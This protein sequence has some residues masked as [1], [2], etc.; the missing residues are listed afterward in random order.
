MVVKANLLF[1]AAKAM[2]IV[3]CVAAG[4]LA[5]SQEAAVVESATNVL[6][7]FLSMPNEG[8][9]AAM[10]PC[11]GAGDRAVQVK[12]PWWLRCARQRPRVYRDA[13]AACGDAGRRDETAAR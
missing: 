12:V 8:S 5:Q 13:K 11:A 10:W 4:A 2:V 6:T 1:G 3:H 7:E 9:R